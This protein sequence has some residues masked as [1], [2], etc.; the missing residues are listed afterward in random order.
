MNKIKLHHD[1]C[2]INKCISESIK[3]INSSLNTNKVSI[4]YN[5]DDKLDEYIQIDENRF[6]QLLI[7]VLLSIVNIIST[8]NNTVFILLNCIRISIDDNHDKLCIK[9]SLTHK[10]N[11]NLQELRK[12]LVDKIATPNGNTKIF[13]GID[14][15]LQIAKKI[16]NLFNGTIKIGIDNY[17]I[18]CIYLI[19][20]QKVKKEKKMDKDILN[21][22]YFVILSEKINLRLSIYCIFENQ[23]IDC[24]SFST[25]IEFKYFLKKYSNE[26]KLNSFI[27]LTDLDTSDFPEINTIIDISDWRVD[28]IEKENF[29]IDEIIKKINIEKQDK[30]ILIVE[31][32]KDNQLLFSTF[33]SILGWKNITITNNGQEA[34]DEV[35]KLFEKN[36]DF[37]IIFMDIN[38]PI[39]DGITANKHIKEKYK[40]CQDR[41]PYVI[42]LTAFSLDYVEEMDDLINKPI[43]QMSQLEAS[44]QK[45]LYKK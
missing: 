22:R 38:M 25:I 24:S 41:N 17:N 42:A 26:N 13:E 43:L 1:K 39:M 20:L 2:N 36:E 40:N 28:N 30:K 45:Y 19:D 29:V 14:L 5:V 3:I 27:L 35:N 12:R 16:S 31:D 9:I 18:L 21:G 33:L 4:N 34:L 8:T 37:D 11:K 32:N 44:L 15:N 6:K 7:N 10:N 23:N